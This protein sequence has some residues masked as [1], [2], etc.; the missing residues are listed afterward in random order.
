MR[1]VVDCRLHSLDNIVFNVIVSTTPNLH[2]FVSHSRRLQNGLGILLII[3]SGVVVMIVK[4]A[5]GLQAVSR[6][7][8]HRTFPNSHCKL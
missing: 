7:V 8:E 4:T 1:H 3:L 5:V 2:N 6:M